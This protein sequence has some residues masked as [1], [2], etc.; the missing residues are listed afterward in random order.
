MLINC[1]KNHASRLVMME[2]ARDAGIP[3]SSLSIVLEPEVASVY[4]MSSMVLLQTE[5]IHN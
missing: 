3:E 4:C 5:T 1:N 2:A